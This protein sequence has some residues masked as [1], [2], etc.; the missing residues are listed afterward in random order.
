MEQANL[1][2]FTGKSCSVRMTEY[3]P[4]DPII[5]NKDDGRKMMD[6][7]RNLIKSLPTM[8]SLDRGNFYDVL[9]KEV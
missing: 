6:K 7:D 4:K 3:S 2:R 8:K 5:G 1:T 9:L